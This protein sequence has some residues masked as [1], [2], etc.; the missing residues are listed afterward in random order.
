MMAEYY[1]AN[2]ALML[3]LS[4]RENSSARPDAW[5]SIGCCTGI[6]QVY[7]ERH[8]RDYIHEC[9]QWLV[10]SPESINAML[11][12]FTVNA[13]YGVNIWLAKL[14]RANGDTRLALQYYVGASVAAN[15]PKG[16]IN[17]VLG[18]M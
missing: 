1:G 3:S 5:S 11:Q 8:W 6:M 14:D 16:Y 17:D 12:Q 4:K 13:C 15:V 18:G 9:A 7:V 2:P 10:E